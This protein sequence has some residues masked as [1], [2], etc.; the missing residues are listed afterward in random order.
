M[1]DS[2]GAPEGW[3]F[4]GKGPG[5]WGEIDAVIGYDITGTMI[6]GIEFTKQNETPGLGARIAETWFKEQFRGKSGP[7]TMM[8]E[9]TSTQSN[10]FDAI[11]GA[12][13]TSSAVMQIIND[14]NAMVQDMM[15]EGM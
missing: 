10:Q 11:T 2:S 4:Y 5:L 13:R 12:T 3:V 14:T 8:A 15:E 9:G 7:F 6:T 1:L